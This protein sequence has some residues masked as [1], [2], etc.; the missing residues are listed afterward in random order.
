MTITFENDND[1]IVYALEKVISY[2]R[3]TQ[4][5]F[6]AQCVW[7]LASIIGLQQGLI[8]YIDTVNQ[9]SNITN[10][11]RSHPV[12]S[13]GTIN[14]FGKVVSPTP[15]DT[16]K[17]PRLSPKGNWIHPERRNQV[18][19]TDLDIS[20]LDLNDSDNHPRSKVIDQTKVFLSKSR[21][22]RKAFNKQ[23]KDQLSRTQSGKVRAK[24]L[25]AGQKK[26]LQCIPKDTISDYL[27]DRK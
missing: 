22:E 12:N 18:D 13:P 19:N 17:D 10:K 27:A 6:V 21:K 25:T 2:T 20:D 1:V 7:W 8:I 3:R 9:R 4:Q 14:Q 5:I 26:Y 15:R 24:P 23:K 16:Q 11:G